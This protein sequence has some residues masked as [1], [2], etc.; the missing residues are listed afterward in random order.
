LFKTFKPINR[1]A[2]LKPLIKGTGKNRLVSKRAAE[3]V[4][5]L[6]FRRKKRFGISKAPRR[7]RASF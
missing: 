2:R 7:T 5:A 3:A 1:C 6:G 4:T